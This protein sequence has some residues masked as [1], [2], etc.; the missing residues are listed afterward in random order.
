MSAHSS[1]IVEVKGKR[2]LHPCPYCRE[3]GAKNQCGGAGIVVVSDNLHL[4]LLLR[5]M[6][7]DVRGIN[8]NSHF[9]FS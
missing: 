9:D 3:L 8:K 1:L 5:I 4:V 2:Y 6:R 7:Q